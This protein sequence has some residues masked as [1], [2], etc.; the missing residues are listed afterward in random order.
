MPFLNSLKPVYSF[1]DL[2]MLPGFQAHALGDISIE[3]RLGNV[4][5]QTPFVSS[6]MDTITETEMAVAINDYGGIGMIH[7]NCSTEEQVKMVIKAHDSGVKVGA[8]FS[9][10]DAERAIKLSEYADVL[11]MDIAHADKDSVYA[12]T[13]KILKDMN[14]ECSLIFGSVG[15]YN[16]A[17]RAIHTFEGYNTFR[18]LRCGIG[19]GSI[20]TTSEVTRCGSPTAYAV[21]QAYE[22]SY[23]IGTDKVV[24]IVADGGMMNAGDVALALALGSDAIMSGRLFAGTDETPGPVFGHPAF[25]HGAKHYRGMGSFGAIEKRKA[26]DRY[27]KS[28]KTVPEGIEALV[29]YAG[30]VREVM[31]HLVD[32]LCA[33]LGYA[34]AVNI[35]ELKST[36]TLAIVTPEDKYITRH[37]M[38]A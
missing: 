1:R 20:C 5:L 22:A 30:P 12:M 16:A 34:G 2:I 38:K 25:D 10:Y 32:G 4:E 21:A 13:K 36:A 3:T 27:G 8:G 7:R 6:C 11:M 35:A 28:I 37:L 18:G 19:S 31:A 26:E 23:D 15:T 24:S 29:P 33:A 17:R 14:P 9:P